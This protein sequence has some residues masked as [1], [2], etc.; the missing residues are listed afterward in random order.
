M[1]KN[2]AYRYVSRCCSL[3][4][5]DVSV[6]N[7]SCLNVQMVNIGLRV[8]SR[9]DP[10]KLPKIYRMLGQNWEERILPSVCNEVCGPKFGEFEHYSIVKYNSKSSRVEGA[11]LVLHLM[12]YGVKG[13]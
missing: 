4:N 7:Y 6:D 8:L 13:I 11:N 9:P 12:C 1:L 5:A 10:S 2:A 3:R